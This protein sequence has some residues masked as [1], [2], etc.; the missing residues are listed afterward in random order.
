M[1][2]FFS[3]E[4]TCVG[5]SNWQKNVSRNQAFINKEEILLELP[6]SQTSTLK[7]KIFQAFQVSWKTKW[8]LYLDI[9]MKVHD[10]LFMVQLD[11]SLD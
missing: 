11:Y 8:H 3:E 5:T 6:D 9:F 2:E 10:L 4:H 7:S 1:D